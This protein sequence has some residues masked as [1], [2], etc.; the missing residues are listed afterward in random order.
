MGHATLP[1]R[2]IASSMHVT[3]GL[4]AMASAHHAEGREFDTWWSSFWLCSDSCFS[5]SNSN[6]GS[7]NSKSSRVCMSPVA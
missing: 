7:S 2:T 3:C 5:G 6:S 1:L 4:V